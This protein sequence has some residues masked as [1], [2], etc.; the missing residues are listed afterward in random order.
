LRTEVNRF[1]AALPE[2]GAIAVSGFEKPE[3]ND[4][5]PA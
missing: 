4:W 2:V 1:S 3:K 5:T